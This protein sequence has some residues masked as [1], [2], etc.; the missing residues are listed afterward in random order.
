MNG[1]LIFMYLFINYYFINSCVV[2]FF[3]KIA[4]MTSE[5][6]LPLPTVLLVI[7]CSHA[8]GECRNGIFPR[9]QCYLTF[10]SPR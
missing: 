8:G 6:I 4:V 10:N 9:K 2:N 3:F 5:I 7:D 1:Y